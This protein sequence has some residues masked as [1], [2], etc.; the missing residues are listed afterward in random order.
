M[1][2]EHKAPVSLAP[3][4][5]DLYRNC[6]YSCR[7]CNQSRSNQP[8][9]DQ[10]GRR[11]LDPCTSVW[12][13]MFR[14]DG[15]EL[16]AANDD[17]FYTAV[18]YDLNDDRKT[19]VRRNRRRVVSK[20]EFIRNASTSIKQLL[21]AAIASTESRAKFL[22]AAARLQFLQRM[23]L[24]QVYRFAASRRMHRLIVGAIQTRVACF[25]RSSAINSSK[26]RALVRDTRSSSI[27]LARRA[28]RT[29][30]ARPRAAR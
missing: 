3:S 28:G 12:G 14:R 18:A 11:L 4:Q 20:L 30:R 23:A 13:Q 22:E 5:Q 8:L 7:F 26:S 6:F 17:A 16:L 15:D 1:W 21:E 10:Q 27:L 29:R 2:I 9:T 19:T 24:E 25:R